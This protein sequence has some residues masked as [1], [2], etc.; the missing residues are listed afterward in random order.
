MKKKYKESRIKGM[1]FETPFYTG[2]KGK[3]SYRRFVNGSFF[4]FFF[5]WG[6]LGLFLNGEYIKAD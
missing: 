5:F 3:F 4:F 6:L 1:F 2:Q